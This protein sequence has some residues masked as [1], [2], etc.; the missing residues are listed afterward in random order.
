MIQ[1]LDVAGDRAVRPWSWRWSGPT[2]RARRPTGSARRSRRIARCR[3][4]TPPAEVI[5]GEGLLVERTHRSAGRRPQGLDGG[6]VRGGTRDRVDL[7]IAPARPD[8][9]AVGARPR[10]AGQPPARPPRPRSS[11]RSSPG[12]GRRV[13][14]S[15]R[16][17]RAVLERERFSLVALLQP[18][19]WSYM[20]AD[21]R[22]EV[23]RRALVYVMAVREWQLRHDGRF[24]DR[25]DELVPDELPS[26]A[27][28]PVFRPAVPLH[29][30]RPGVGP[31]PAGRLA[32]APLAAR[33]PAD[34]QRRTQRP[35]RPRPA[36]AGQQ[37]RMTATSS[38]PSSPRH[39]RRR[40][41]RASRGRPRGGPAPA[42]P[43]ARG[44][45]DNECRL[46]R[47]ERSKRT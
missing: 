46:T 30:L 28:R 40:G 35:R 27:D 15:L 45:G 7:G 22:N 8:R 31:V 2:P 5:R 41:G 23:E 10:P 38:S 18:N 32:A 21:D 3:A 20:T 42:L 36:R 12:S 19:F 6:D 4:M 29:D 34:L 37:A 25:L 43:D 13:R 33:H 11:R 44:R 17:R 9:H 47:D 24:P 16:D 39:P 26:P 1:A 14:P